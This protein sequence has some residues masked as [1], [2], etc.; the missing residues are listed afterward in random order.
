MSL[1]VCDLVTAFS[2]CGMLSCFIAS[3]NRALLCS[4]W[5][6]WLV[7]VVG[8][9]LGFRPIF[10]FSLVQ[11]LGD[12]RARRADF[13]ALRVSVF[14]RRTTPLHVRALQLSEYS[15]HVCCC[16]AG[17]VVVIWLSLVRFLGTPFCCVI[18]VSRV[19][20]LLFECGFLYFVLYF[21]LRERSCLMLIYLFLLRLSTLEVCD[22]CR[23]VVLLVTVCFACSVIYVSRAQWLS[24]DEGFVAVPSSHGA[25]ALL[26]VI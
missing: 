17:F 25:I 2:I 3:H 15:D 23:S 12:G 10:S 4:T 8:P 1:C 19:N 7:F 11:K 22:F 13:D 9:P 24:I 5:F 21:K 6:D 18:W 14:D 20:L 16:V 26:C